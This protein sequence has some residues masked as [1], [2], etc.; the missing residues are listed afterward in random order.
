MDVKLAS[1]LKTGVDGDGDATV[2]PS[3]GDNE[4]EEVW[5]GIG[6]WAFCWLNLAHLLNKNVAENSCFICYNHEYYMIL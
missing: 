4:E 6:K 1:P 3:L 2:E 5:D